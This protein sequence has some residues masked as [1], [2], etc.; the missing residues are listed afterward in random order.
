MERLYKNL[1]LTGE[2]VMIQN[3]LIIDFL[4]R[5]TGLSSR[6]EAW[7]QPV[8]ERKNVRCPKN[9]LRLR[10]IR[11]K[12]NPVICEIYNNLSSARSVLRKVDGMRVGIL[13]YKYLL[14]RE[15]EKGENLFSR[16]VHTFCTVSTPFNSKVHQIISYC[17]DL[18]YSAL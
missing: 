5:F 16:I 2:V 9:R 4:A 11:K 15:Q 18:T 10:Q 14:P 17:S 1:S 12:P 8:S 7:F 6:S 13:F 3:L